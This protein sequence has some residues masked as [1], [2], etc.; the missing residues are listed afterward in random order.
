MADGRLSQVGPGNSPGGDAKDPSLGANQFTQGSKEEETLGR[1][2]VKLWQFREFLIQEKGLRTACSTLLF[3]FL[4]WVAF[5]WLS[6]VHT[7]VG[8]SFMTT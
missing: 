3:T 5:I 7:D 2:N 8:G 4:L 6:S 1:Y